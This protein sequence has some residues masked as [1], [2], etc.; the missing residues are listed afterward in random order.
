MV[1]NKPQS[2]LSSP[3]DHGRKFVRFT[4]SSAPRKSEHRPDGHEPPMV[5]L[6]AAFHRVLLNSCHAG[7]HASQ[8]PG[9]D[10]WPR[11][12]NT[13]ILLLPQDLDLADA[14]VRPGVDP[15]PLTDFLGQPLTTFTCALPEGAYCSGSTG[16]R[17]ASAVTSSLRMP[18]S[19]PRSSPLSS[20]VLL[21]AGLRLA[22]MPE[23]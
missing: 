10:E 21:F 23:A 15:D 4:M 11:W 6:I 16:R 19:E 9:Y 22:G 1:A 14:G 7:L 18:C 3:C 8:L 12:A 5:A 20:G 2:P 17:V 13:H